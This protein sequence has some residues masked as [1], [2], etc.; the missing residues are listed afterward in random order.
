MI[1]RH[2]R[3]L[4]PLMM[5]TLLALA[6]QAMLTFSRSGMYMAGLGIIAASYYYVQ[7]PK[8]RRTLV[9]S[10]VGILVLLLFVVVP[11]INSFT[12]G[13]LEERFRD[14]QPTGRQEIFSADLDIWRRHPLIGAG[15]GVSR[16]L[17]AEYHEGLAAH[18]E[19]SRL[20]AEHGLLGF[21]AM[22]LLFFMSI[23]ACRRANG[24]WFQG[25]AAAFVAWALFYMLV[26]AMR[27]VLPSF[28]FGLA[29]IRIDET[30]FLRS[31]TRVARPAEEI[32]FFPEEVIE[33]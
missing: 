1:S 6:C 15:P 20:V 32:L 21:F 5:V 2:R 4:R 13:K 29:F 14:T 26:N 25:V 30:G 31:L 8:L 11:R 33:R 24:M 18:T 7:N 23:Q 17:H 27:L 22:C 19:F 9:W 16:F 3:N 12:G 10:A 28:L